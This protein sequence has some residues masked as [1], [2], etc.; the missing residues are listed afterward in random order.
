MIVTVFSS[1]FRFWFHPSYSY[2]K[3]FASLFKG[4]NSLCTGA[5]SLFKGANSLLKGA[6]SLFKGAN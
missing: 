2:K 1:G 5:K 4:A 3:K 6:N